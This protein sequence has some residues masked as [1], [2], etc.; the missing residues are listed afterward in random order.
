M[1]SRT[2]EAWGD[3]LAFMYVLVFCGLRSSEIR[4]LTWDGIN[5]KTNVLKV[6]QRA[7][8][9]G[10]IGTP[11]S[12]AGTRDIKFVRA[13]SLTWCFLRARVPFKIMPTS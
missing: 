8:K 4:A 13:A 11:K 10:R 3:W 7:D 12:D 5:L 6:R 9:W 1:L 2:A